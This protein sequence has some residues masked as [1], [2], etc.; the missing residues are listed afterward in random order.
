M[1]R[2]KFKYSSSLY[3]LVLMCVLVC[4]SRRVSLQLCWSFS[5][6]FLAKEC[7][8]VCDSKLKEAKKEAETSCLQRLKQ[9]QKIVWV[10]PALRPISVMRVFCWSFVC[11]SNN[12]HTCLMVRVSIKRWAWLHFIIFNIVQW[13]QLS[14][15]STITNYCL[16]M[17]SISEL[18]WFLHR[19]S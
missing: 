1:P 9:Q 13:Y 18:V 14:M 17:L 4:N 5:F 11:I 7:L 12:K 10:F 2:H 3:H 8:D 15:I 19:S 16:V 6:F